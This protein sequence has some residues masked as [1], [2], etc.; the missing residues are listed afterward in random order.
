MAFSEWEVHFEVQILMKN[1]RSAPSLIKVA[2]ANLRHFLI[3]YSRVFLISGGYIDYPPT[4]WHLH[5]QNQCYRYLGSYSRI[6]ERI[7]FHHSP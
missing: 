5:L 6:L 7:L 1:N 3:D 4:G 2:A